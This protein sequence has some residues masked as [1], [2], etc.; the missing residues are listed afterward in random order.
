MKKP[1]LLLFVFIVLLSVH[2]F[3]QLT[4]G[5]KAH[6]T[7]AGSA[8]DVSG[9]NNNGTLNGSPT[10]TS[11]RFGSSNCAYQF[12]GT[13]TDYISVNYSADFN[14]PATGAFSISLWFQGGSPNISDN[15]FL[16]RKNNP[17]NIQNL[18]YNLSLY[19]VNKPVFGSV[20]QGVWSTVTTYPNA[21]PN[22][23]HLVGIYDNK[24]WYIYEDNILRDSDLSQSIGITPS[25]GDISIG[26][27]FMG[28]LDDVR[29]YNRALT[30]SEIDQLYNFGGDCQTLSIEEENLTDDFSVYPNPASSIL[31]ITTSV[32]DATVYLFDIT[33][34]TVL[35]K[36]MNAGDESID[37]S[38]LREGTYLIKIKKAEKIQTKLIIKQN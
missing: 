20:N 35:E 33:G 34:R 32:N 11:D 25:T 28:K 2:S 31:H 15:E 24:K 3:G 29:F 5:L 30:V 10:L 36:D 6:Y 4:N 14:I 26:K 19:D 37:I 27:Y 13:G 16:F 8:N 17:T 22:W 23:H 9:Q 38:F 18:E 12:P 21:D 1:T 7:F